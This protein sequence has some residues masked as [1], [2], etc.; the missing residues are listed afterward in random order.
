MDEPPRAL[1]CRCEGR[2]RKKVTFPFAMATMTLGWAV[3]VVG[4]QNPVAAQAAQGRGSA[5]RG[6]RPQGPAGPLLRL[7]DGNPDLTGIWNG[8]GGSGGDGP[9]MLPWA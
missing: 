9:N 8:F 3:S 2:G 1:L 7:A 5:G 6:A 4:R